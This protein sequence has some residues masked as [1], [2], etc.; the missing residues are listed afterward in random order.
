MRRASPVGDAD[1]TR[2]LVSKMPL[3][4]A[5]T[6]HDDEAGFDEVV[7]KVSGL[8]ILTGHVAEGCE[9]LAGRA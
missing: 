3:P 1:L 9:G 7:Y 4:S 5:C 2:R 8:I 6:R